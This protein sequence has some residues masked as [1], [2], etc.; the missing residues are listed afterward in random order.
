MIEIKIGLEFNQSKERKLITSLVNYALIGQNSIQSQFQSLVWYGLYTF[1]VTT[2]SLHKFPYSYF[3]V[4]AM[5]FKNHLQ[6]T[7]AVVDEAVRVPSHGTE[8][9][10]RTR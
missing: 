2:S 5:D 1:F 3:V 6:W 10:S 8:I 4:Y 9:N 7:V